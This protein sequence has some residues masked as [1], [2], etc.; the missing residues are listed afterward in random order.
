MPTLQTRT[1]ETGRAPPT[2]LAEALDTVE[3]LID[4]LCP[5]GNR[6]GERALVG[7]LGERYFWQNTTRD[8]KSSQTGGAPTSL[9][10]RPL[11]FQVPEIAISPLLLDIIG[12]A[13]A[14]PNLRMS[15]T[16][17]A[18]AMSGRGRVCALADLDQIRGGRRVE[19]LGDVKA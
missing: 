15:H 12:F 19:R 4:A 17:R 7:C 11:L 14:P 3:S 10:T 5:Q 13:V 6:T 18:C 2:T 8:H 16:K 1:P 9:L